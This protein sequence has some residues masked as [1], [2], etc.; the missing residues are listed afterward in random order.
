MGGF[1]VAYF[2][3]LV[4]VS[5]SAPLYLQADRSPS[6]RIKMVAYKPVLQKLSCESRRLRSLGGMF[7]VQST[8]LPPDSSLWERS[9]PK[10][11]LI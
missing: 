6:A 8:E 4:Y 7:S 9:K 11:T 2:T 10:K 1:L 3:A 5:A